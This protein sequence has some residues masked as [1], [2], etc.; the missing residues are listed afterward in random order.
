LHENGALVYMK[1]GAL[2]CMKNRRFKIRILPVIAFSAITI[3][4]VRAKSY[5]MDIGFWPDLPVNSDTDLTDI[6]CLVKAD[7]CL[8][9]SIWA[10]LTLS[11]LLIT[12]QMKIKK[13]RLYIPMAVYTLSVLVSFAL[14]D[15]K[16]I[17]WYGAMNRFEGT[18]TI[19]C[20]MFMLFYTINVVDDIYDSF[21]VI[22]PTLVAVFIANVIGITQLFGKDILISDAGSMIISNGMKLKGEFKPGQV[23]QTVFNMN[24][25][26]LY[27]TL[28]VPL[29]VYLIYREIKLYRLGKH[30]SDNNSMQYLAENRILALMDGKPLIFTILSTIFLLLIVL[31]VYG[32]DSIGGVIGICAG[33]MAMIIGFSNKRSTKIILAM[34]SV[35]GFVAVLS[36]MYYSGEDRR[37]CIDYFRTGEGSLETSIDGNELLIEFDRNTKEYFVTDAQ[38]KYLESSVYKGREGN[39]EIE[40]SRFKGKLVLIPIEIEGR[41]ILCFG[42]YGEEFQFLMDEDEVKYINPQHYTV[43][44]DKV[45]SIGFERHLSAGS[46]RAYIWSRTLPLIK[47]HLLFGSGADTFMLVFPQND[48]AGKY[49]CGSNLNI[50]FDKAHNMYLNMIICTG[51]VSCIAFI[52]LIAMTLKKAFTTESNNILALVLAAGIIGFMVAGLFNDSNVCIMPI[53]FSFLGVEISRFASL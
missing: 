37:V 20:Y 49:S 3:L 53:F 40:D 11:Y 30:G 25:V 15:Y 12:G 9:I 19:L 51:I 17:A 48:Y 24:Y 21:C 39:Y 38:G 4:L 36:F 8:Y 45:E 23:Y 46:G 27:L 34:L 47:K 16:L 44:L 43:S 6:F 50:V 31:N 41:S 29:I 7:A 14:S 2:V 35:C 5:S 32:A 33:I 52:I 1:N 10:F 22:I 26:G 42:L 28:I 18:R 13:T